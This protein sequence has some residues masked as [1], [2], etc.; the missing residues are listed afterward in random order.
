MSKTNGTA[1]TTIDGGD[2]PTV[3]AEVEH[4]WHRVLAGR[5]RT[6][7]EDLAAE[8]GWSRQRLWSRFR[9]QP[10]VGPKRAVRLVRLDRAAR[11]LVAGRPAAMVAAEA[12]YVDQSHLH[13]EVRALTGLTPAE[14]AAAP[15][16]AI[17]DVAWPQ[18]APR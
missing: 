18:L 14:L 15:W 7:V 2:G 10:G 1:G 17:D 16:L 11:H 12:G 6:R 13:R 8:V 3:D 4:A 5:G 9:S